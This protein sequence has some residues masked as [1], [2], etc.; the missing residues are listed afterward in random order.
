MNNKIKIA[1]LYGVMCFLLA[2]G[3][4]IQFKT[5]QSSGTEVAKTTKENELRDNVLEMKE[6]YEKRYKVLEAK[7]KELDT[8]ISNASNNDSNSSELSEQ[9]DR[10]NSEIGLTALSGEGL[11][12]TLEDGPVETSSSS[13]RDTVVH[14]QDLIAVVNDLCTAGAEAISINGQRIVSSTA[15]TCIGNVIKINDEKIGTPF[16]ICAIGSKSRLYGA[17]T[18]NGRTLKN[19]EREGIK[20]SVKKSDSVLVPRYDGI[21]SFE[22]AQ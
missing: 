14:D 20:V 7:E 15:I 22:Y 12:I 16:E 18:M 3:I 4:S 21:I 1:I 5:V 11:I 17:M 6:K 10:I 9:L 13:I 8:L 19:R 2:L